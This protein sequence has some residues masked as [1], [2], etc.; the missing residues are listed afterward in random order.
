MVPSGSWVKPLTWAACS[1]QW[2]FVQNLYN[3]CTTCKWNST[4]YNMGFWIGKKCAAFTWL[5]NLLQIL[6]LTS[7]SPTFSPLTQSWLRLSFKPRAL[8]LG[9]ILTKMLRW[10]WV[11]LD[12]AY[13]DLWNQKRLG[14][15][16]VRLWEIMEKLF[17][18]STI[19]N[20]IKLFCKIR[21]VGSEGRPPICLDLFCKWTGLVL[22]RT[23]CNLQCDQMYCGYVGQLHKIRKW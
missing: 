22:K 23:Q 3:M 9:L 18:P 19:K 2:I 11:F 15:T 6:P 21:Q 8:S 7:L 17:K 5:W 14:L 1:T 4:C 20:F 13:E 12:E 16:W 10:N